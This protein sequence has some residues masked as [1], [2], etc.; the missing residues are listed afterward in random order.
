MDTVWYIANFHAHS[1][2]WGWLTDGRKNHLDTI[3]KVYRDLG[4]TCINISNYN[5]I[6]LKD[7]VSI[8]CYEHGVNIFK[9]HQLCIG[10]QK[11][12]WFDLFFWQNLKHKQHI[13]NQLKK[14]TDFVAICHPAFSGSYEPKDF[15]SLYNYDAIEVFNHYRTSIAHWDSA[16]SSGYYAVLL[17]GDDLHDITNMNETGVCFTMIN[18]DITSSKPVI[19]QLKKG[20]HYGVRVAKQPNENLEIK[21]TRMANLVIPKKID[22]IDNLLNIEL[23]KMVKEI[24]FIG[25]S[26]EIKKSCSDTCQATY[27]FAP[28]DTYIR[29]EVFDYEDNYYIFNPVIKT[30]TAF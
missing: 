13:L 24:K 20:V 8:P 2:S 16:L 5:K 21:K 1:K 15:S 25:Q 3:Y 27:L 18:N 30:S 12:K 19:E 26:G 6:T 29:I 17:T 14:T 28:E 11:V 10:A 9:R 22:I 4:Y 23:N 7:S